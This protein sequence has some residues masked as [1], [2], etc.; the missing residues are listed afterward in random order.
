MTLLLEKVRA[1]RAALAAI[2]DGALATAETMM[3]VRE[4]LDADQAMAFHAAAG[5]ATSSGGP[6]SASD[7]P[8]G[9]D[10]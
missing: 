5:F 1:Q 6:V 2:R 7:H 9:R 3:S 4:L 10:G 8:S